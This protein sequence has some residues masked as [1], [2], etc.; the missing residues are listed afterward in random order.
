[1]KTLI[2]IALA[3]TSLSAI[4]CAVPEQL[5][6]KTL[7][8]VADPA[9]SPG[10]PNAGTIMKLRF[11]KDGYENKILSK[12]LLVRGQY[13]YR[14]LHDTVGLMEANELYDGRATRYTLVLTCLN[15]NSGTAVFTQTQ[16]AIPPDNRQN[17]VRYT[18]DQ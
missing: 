13:R 7:I 4:A 15:D 16:G 11:G 2:A 9:Y 18:I 1:M 8:N 17:T 14:K 6:G 10:N 5:D 3:S 12:G